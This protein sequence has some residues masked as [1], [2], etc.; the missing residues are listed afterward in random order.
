MANLYYVIGAS[1]AGKDSLIHYVKDHV[2]LHAPVVF[3]HRFITR[4][5]DAGGENHIALSTR[6]FERRL[7]L[8]CFTMHWYSHQTYY[9]IGTEIDSWLSRGLDVVMNG[10]REY[11]PEALQRYANLIPVL[12][13]VHPTV[14]GARLTARGRETAEQIQRRLVQAVE[15][16]V[17]TQHPRLVRIEN[18]G[19]LDDAGN[20]LL[21]EITKRQQDQCD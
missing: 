17:D 1:G 7:K 9:G 10:S 20:R 15:L 5:A 21:N 2:P 8:G 6:E 16:E 18:N 19:S 13:S 4:P 14:L 12:I 3:A 11:L